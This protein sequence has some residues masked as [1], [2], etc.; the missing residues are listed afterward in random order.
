MSGRFWSF[1]KQWVHSVTSKLANATSPLRWKRW[2]IGIG[3][4]EGKTG[5]V[6]E[7]EIRPS[8]FFRTEKM[9]LL[10][11][12]NVDPRRD[13]RRSRLVSVTVGQMNQIPLDGTIPTWAFGP[14]FYG[15]GVEWDTA[16]PN[17]PIV[18]KFKFL[19]DCSISGVLF[20]QV[21]PISV[22]FNGTCTSAEPVVGGDPLPPDIVKAMSDANQSVNES[23]ST[24]AK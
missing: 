22:P 16:S 17:I 1:L 23:Q 12:S 14:G 3:P 8:Y 21:L 5:D 4:I 24:G 9:Y 20:G 18:L 13:G 11:E 7:I 15:N 6:K 2:Q 10:D 19:E